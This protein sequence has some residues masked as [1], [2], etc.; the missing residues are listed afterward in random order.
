MIRQTKVCIIRLAVG[1]W[2]EAQMFL[3]KGVARLFSGCVT[4]S[5][6]SHKATW[7]CDD[8]SWSHGQMA[9]TYDKWASPWVIEPYTPS[10]IYPKLH[11][12]DSSDRS[13]WKHRSNRWGPNWA[14]CWYKP[15]RCHLGRHIALITVRMFI[16]FCV[17]PGSLDS[18]I[19]SQSEKT[20]ICTD[21]MTLYCYNTPSH[22]L[23]AT[24]A[25]CFFP[26]FYASSLKVPF[27]RRCSK[28]TSL[29]MALKI[30]RSAHLCPD[31]ANRDYT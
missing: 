19:W 5:L 13:Q 3:H 17:P 28:I 8:R 27:Q 22:F 9:E 12:Y 6:P 2:A 15:C 21:S 11:R 7:L 31:L 25:H 14:T 23:R 26:H 30:K 24:I 18:N 29:I 10:Q 20:S 16:N 1:V 4:C